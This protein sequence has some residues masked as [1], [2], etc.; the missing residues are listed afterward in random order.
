MVLQTATR[1]IGHQNV[2]W[3]IKLAKILIEFSEK[4]EKQ[5]TRRYPLK[6]IIPKDDSYEFNIYKYETA[7]ILQTTRPIW[8][9]FVSSG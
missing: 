2:T 5:R 6:Y 1:L 3:Y 7:H 8:V 9:V 4:F